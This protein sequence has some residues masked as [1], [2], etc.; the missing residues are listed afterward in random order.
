MEMPIDISS[1]IWTTDVLPSFLEI[2]RFLKVF[3]IVDNCEEL[4]RQTNKSF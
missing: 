4:G 3:H 1:T 2:V